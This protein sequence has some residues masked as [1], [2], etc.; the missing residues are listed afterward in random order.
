MSKVY[1][2]ER[3]AAGASV[4]QIA[5]ERGVSPQAIGAMLRRSGIVP[6]RR[7]MSYQEMGKLGGR[8]APPLRDRIIDGSIPEPNSGCWLWDGKITTRSRGGDVRGQLSVGDK[9]AFAYRAS[10]QAFR[11]PI[12][13]GLEIDHL[14][15]VPLCVNPAH[16]EAVTHKVNQERG[17]GSRTRCKRGHLFD[18]KNTAVSIIRGRTAVRRCRR[19]CADRQIGYKAR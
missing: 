10:Y 15:R 3:Y 8:P 18:E 12:P 1:V 5:G 17:R 19:C 14:C 9:T 6:E 13:R 7:G 16:L 11:G 2:L 4:S